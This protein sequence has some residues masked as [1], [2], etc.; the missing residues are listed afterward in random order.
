MD[1]PAKKLKIL[2][3]VLSIGETNTTYNEHCLPMVEKRDIAIVTYFRSKITPPKTIQLFEGDDSF[4]GFFRTLKTA[5]NAKEF[6]IIHAHSPH[7]ALLFLIA[8]LF[9]PRRW[10]ASSIV[11]VHDSYQD[12]KLRNKLLFIPVFATFRRVVCCSQASYQS[13]PRFY[14]WLAGKR[15]TFVQNGVDIT[16]VDA[17]LAKTAPRQAQRKGFTTVGVS[18]LIEVKNPFTVLSAFQQGT[19]PSSRMVY[20]GDGALRPELIEKSNALGLD[21]RVTFTGLIPREKVFENLLNADVYISASRGE[22]LPIAVLEAMACRCPVILSDIQP[23]REIA[24]GVDF[25][26]LVDPD[27]VQGFAREIRRFQNMPESERCEIGLRCRR[28]V[29]ERLSLEAMHT[30]YN[31]V[32]AQIAGR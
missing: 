26:P 25:I 8:S 27:D 24:S 10:L 29:E 6:D 15:L 18:R 19:E 28:L 5:L 22:G 11:T 4:S 16:R 9:G 21:G 1:R 12:F 2:H 30:R 14:K 23:H 13:F 3:V 32:Y 7:V 17:T 31:E 20:I